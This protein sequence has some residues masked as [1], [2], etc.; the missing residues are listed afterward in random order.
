[1]TGKTTRT[2][3]H[4]GVTITIKTSDRT[5]T[6]LTVTPREGITVRGPHT[7]TDDEAR[8]LVTRRKYWVYRKLTKL[9]EQAPAN[10]TKTLRDGET[11]TILG[12]PHTLRLT[13]RRPEPHAPA[14]HDDPEHGPVLHLE[15]AVAANLDIARRTLIKAHAET[16]NKWLK[17]NGERITRLTTNPD[18]RI[19]ASPRSRTTWIIRRPTGELSLHWALAQL[20]TLHLRELLHRTL[21]LHSIADGHELNQQLR[22][23]WLGELTTSPRTAAAS[24]SANHCP[25]CDAQ[26][27]T[28]HTNLCGVARCALTGRQRGYCHPGTTCL[29][30]WS[31][32]WPGTDEC[33]EYGFFYR[34]VAGRAEPCN[35]TAEGAEYDY[36]RLYAEC[37]WHIGQQR[38]ILP[39]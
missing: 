13:D 23:L 26:P 16:A 22:T 18:I 24:R 2:A 37:L 33:E 20:P 28:L 4:G 35:A 8:A 27:G 34:A 21:N 30:I 3:N 10:P 38:M 7:L 29:T 5:T 14:V 36:N 9:S 17:E 31:G 25:Q 19:T 1:M 32:R 15:Q 11:F 6:D 39:V 12:T